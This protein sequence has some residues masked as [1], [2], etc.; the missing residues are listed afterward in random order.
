MKV[1][2]EFATLRSAIIHDPVNAF[3]FSLERMREIRSPQ[4]MLEHPES[5]PVS[6]ARIQQQHAGFRE[7]LNRF[8]VACRKPVAQDGAYCQVFTRDPCFAIGETLYMGAL[9]DAHRGAELSGLVELQSWARDVHELAGD[10]AA[11]EGG[12][13]FVLRGGKLVLVGMRRHTNEEGFVRLATQLGRVG[14]RTVR[15]PHWALH[16]DCCLAPL[17]NGEALYV[18][19]RLPQISVAILRQFFPKLRPLDEQEGLQQLSASILWLDPVNALTSNAAPRTN[20]LLQALGYR[21]HPLEFSDMVAMWGGVRRVAC[22]LE[23]A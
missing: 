1:R 12:D 11:I 3:D 14:A 4:D 19:G 21:V 20:E 8:G 7:V 15:I 13:V 2:D 22:P 17:P 10:G 5:G 18:P 6:M 9:H 23:R 16:L